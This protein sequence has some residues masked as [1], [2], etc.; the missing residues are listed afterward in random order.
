MRGAVVDVLESLTGVVQ[1]CA[2]STVHQVLIYTFSGCVFKQQLFAKVFGWLR[3]TLVS[4]VHLLNLY[5]NYSKYV[6]M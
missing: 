4:M 3:P 6:P 2:V 5:H 1:G